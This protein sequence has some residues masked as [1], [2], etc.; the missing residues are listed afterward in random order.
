MLL[1][2]LDLRAHLLP[3]DVLVHQQILNFVADQLH[4]RNRLQK[5]TQIHRVVYAVLGDDLAYQI[6]QISIDVHQLHTYH[7][8]ELSKLGKFARLIPP[9]HIDCLGYVGKENSGLVD[10][11]VDVGELLFWVSLETF[12]LCNFINIGK[13][14]ELHQVGDI[15]LGEVLK[16][17]LVFINFDPYFQFFKSAYILSVI[18][19]LHDE[20][21]NDGEE[22][23]GLSYGGVVIEFGNQLNQ[24]ILRA[25]S[26]DGVLVQFG[27]VERTYVGFG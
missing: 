20:T 17:L 5:T 23:N 6:P 12:S 26:L 8:V 27:D 14:G 16:P 10:D 21:V 11:A 2:E 15:G 25:L 24:E 3:L 9:N 4:F 1:L 13:G 19:S 22:L 18:I 7:P